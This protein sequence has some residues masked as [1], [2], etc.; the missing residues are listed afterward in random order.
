M[1]RALQIFIG[2]LATAL[3][4]FGQM[5][6]ALDPAGVQ[7][8]RIS[9][10]WWFFCIVLSSIYLLVLIFVLFLI[11]RLRETKDNSPMLMPSVRGEKIRTGVVAL[12]V[13]I[14]VVLL[15][16]FLVSD[17]ATGRPMHSLSNPN[18]LTI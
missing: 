18:A 4:A 5:Q 2:L 6:S 14:T 9:R 17:F 7:A 15:F 8:A 11:P 12:A 1:C 13:G 3:T 16:V 10:L